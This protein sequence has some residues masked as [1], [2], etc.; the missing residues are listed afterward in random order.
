MRRRDEASSLII[1]IALR[2]LRSR[3]FVICLVIVECCGIQTMPRSSAAF[4]G[5]VR[6]PT[7]ATTVQ[8]N[9]LLT[10]EIASQI[11]RGRG[12]VATR[13]NLGVLSD[14]A[15]RGTYSNYDYAF[16]TRVPTRLVGLR[17]SAPNPNH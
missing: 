11:E 8:S 4:Q 9:S 10:D 14:V 13:A 1:R 5:S 12:H 15:V 17:P 2:N 7:L 3:I 16:S 6:I